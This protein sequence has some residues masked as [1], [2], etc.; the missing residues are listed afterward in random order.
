MGKTQEVVVAVAGNLAE[1]LVLLDQ[2]QGPLASCL[3]GGLG[4]GAGTAACWEVDQAAGIAWRME[5]L[6]PEA[7]LPGALVGFP[8]E[9]K[10]SMMHHAESLS[11][12]M[13]YCKI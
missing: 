3:Q 11:Y 4:G 12:S 2:G 10:K 13:P 8:G 5:V 9:K 7:Y 1:R 6:H